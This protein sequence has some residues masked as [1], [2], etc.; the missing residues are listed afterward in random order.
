MSW[1]RAL[2]SLL[3]ATCVA[4]YFGTGWS[5]VLFSFPIRPQLTVSNYYLE[6]VPQVTAATHFFTWMTVVMMVSAVV[7]IV[8][9][10]GSPLVWAPIIILA[11]AVAAAT[12]LT[13]IKILPLNNLMSAGITDAAELNSVLDKWIA[14]NRVRVALWTVQWLAMMFY[15]G[16]GLGDARRDGNP[17]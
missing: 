6:F 2:N 14:L 16:A 3:L 17:R 15:F 4:M 1:F 10:R 11:A 9:E 8:T 12:A 7:M 5:L 13:V